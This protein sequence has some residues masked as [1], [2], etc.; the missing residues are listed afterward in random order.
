[1]FIDDD[2]HTIAMKKLSLLQEFFVLEPDLHLSKEASGGM[3]F[4]LSDIVDDLTPQKG[5]QIE[6]SE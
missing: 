4:F 5:N 6:V 1:M 2:N 3:F